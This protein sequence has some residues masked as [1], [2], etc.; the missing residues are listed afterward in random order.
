MQPEN[1]TRS[2]Y[3]TKASDQDDGV[4]TFLA[5]SDREDS[6]GDIVVQDGISL[7]RYKKNPIILHQHNHSAPIGSGKAY[8]AEDGLRVDVQLAPS[9]ISEFID[10][11]RGLV[12]AKI[13]RAVSIGFSPLEWE[14]LRDKEGNFTGYKFLK[15]TLNEISIVSVPANDEAL[16]IAKSF[17]LSDRRLRELFIPDLLKEKQQQNK[18]RVKALKAHQGTISC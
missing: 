12:K 5:S 11:I 8:L 10:S 2:A 4:Y 14:P 6:Y 13:L 1:Y 7:K 17:N 16:A 15:S 9:G 18:N 3:L